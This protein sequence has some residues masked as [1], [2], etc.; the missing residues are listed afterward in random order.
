MGRLKLRAEWQQAVVESSVS[1]FHNSPS[2]C[3]SA[4]GTERYYVSGGRPTGA[5]DGPRA[6]SVLGW[7]I[8]YSATPVHCYKRPKLNTVRI[9]ATRHYGLCQILVTKISVIQTSQLM[10]YRE[11]IAV[12]SE[13]HTKPINTLCGQN[14]ELL[15]VKLAVHIVTTE[16]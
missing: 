12:C 15:D 14:V 4:V 10:L 1:R 3:D 13:I 11:I 2:A 6:A 16:L 5:H 8:S 9:D 7:S